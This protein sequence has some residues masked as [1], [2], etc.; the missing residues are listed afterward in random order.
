MKTEKIEIPYGE[1]KIVII[2]YWVIALILSSLVFITD[3][4][5][6]AYI[7]ARVADN[8]IRYGKPFFNI[9]SSFKASSSTGYLLLISGLSKFVNAIFAIRVIN[10]FSLLFYFAAIHLNV[11]NQKNNFLLKLFLLL[12]TAPIVLLSSYG[13]METTLSI[14]AYLFSVYFLINK[15][16]GW[17]LFFISLAAFFRIEFIFITILTTFYLVVNKNFKISFILSFIPI[18]FFIVFD[19]IYYGTPIP[20][21]AIAKSIGYNF[22][23]KMSLFQSIFFL[24]GDNRSAALLFIIYLGIFFLFLNTLKKIRSTPVYLFLFFLLI[25][26]FFWTKGRSLIFT[27]YLPIPAVTMSIIFFFDINKFNSYPKTRNLFLLL[28]ASI[29]FYLS[30]SNLFREYKLPDHDFSSNQRVKTYLTIAEELF[31]IYP[32]SV[33]VTS[34]V[35]GLGYNFKGKVYDGFG[36]VDPTARRFHP[37]KVPEQRQDYGIGAI[38]A[39]YI[40][41]KNP[42][43]I[44]S[45]SIFTYEFERSD[46][47]NKYNHYLVKFPD[48]NILWGDSGIYIHSLKILPDS[49]LKNFKIN[50]YIKNSE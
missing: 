32:Q 8:F 23:Y 37:L 42:D 48:N 21:A 20:H 26:L 13:G 34:E 49:L 38:P 35:G 7:H 14:A 5:D 4:F 1:N 31:K 17:N 2:I 16:F 12:S 15:K 27:W 18:I 11:R 30:L 24:G 50:N 44:V 29:L 46:V 9:H 33:L 19:F 6:D 47:Y 3:L 40:K 43:F 45:M 10:F 25:I 22:P 28:F 36:L 39:G 41:L